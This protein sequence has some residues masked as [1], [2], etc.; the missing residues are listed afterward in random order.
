VTGAPRAADRFAG[1][2]ALVVGGGQEPGQDIGNGRA[3]AVLLAREGADV[4][5]VDRNLAA[6]EATAEQIRSE[7]GKASALA[8][9]AT[10]ADQVRDVVEE[11]L[12]RTGKLDILHNNV[13]AGK[14]LGGDANAEE[15]TEEVLDISFAVNVKSA[16]LSAKYALPALR[17]SAGS[18]V[19]I[20]SA[21]V[22]HSSPILGYK[23]GKH[24]LVGLTEHLAST[25]ARFGVRVNIV[26]PG[27]M[28]TAMV[29]EREAATQGID[30]EAVIAARAARIPLAGRV[31]T[32]WDVAYA[33]AFLHSDEARFITGAQL[34]VD[35][36]TAVAK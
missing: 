14:G 33:A 15:I 7:G 20:G 5:V 28:N 19:N 4:T 11:V 8:A 32:G 36:G 16:W 22:L 30:R 6:A 10:V 1:R 18:I 9:D 31:G 21:V 13:G 29:V 27:A 35:G 23:A 25:N 17:T 12:S 26:L 24:A 34:V 2:V 3:T